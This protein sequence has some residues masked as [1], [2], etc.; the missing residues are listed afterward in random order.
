MDS[1]LA[2]GQ[3]LQGLVSSYAWSMIKM[4]IL[5]RTVLAS[6]SA[7]LWPAYLLK[8]A[9]AVDNPFNLARN[10]SEKAGRILADAIANKVQGERPVTLVG[11]SLGARVIYTCL[12]ALAQRRAFGLVD[13]VVFVGAP[14]PSDAAHW[15]AMRSVVSG[16]MFNVYSQNDYILGFLYR[17]T[18]IQLGVAG[19]QPIEGVDGVENI[20]LSDD[21][22]G[23]LR[24]PDLMPQILAR[25]GF[26]GVK[27]GDGPIEKEKDDDITLREQDGSGAIGTLIELDDL[28]SEAAPPPLPSRPGAGAAAGP[29][30]NPRRP[31]VARSES[32]TLMRE[33][34]P[35][36]S[37]SLESAT[38]V[39]PLARPARPHPELA[40]AAKTEPAVPT[41]ASLSKA[42]GA[43]SQ[44]TAVGAATTAAKGQKEEE[45][46]VSI[47][48]SRS[49]P[50][51]QVESSWAWAEDEGEE[52]NDD[53]EEGFVGIKMMDNDDDM[54]TYDEPLIVED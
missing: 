42:A 27:G 52:E 5:K 48:K 28:P 10:R 47:P 13:T 7:A 50:P 26:P 9:S 31:A 43:A 16:R 38:A 20:D 23:H 15:R 25:C 36:G 8:T 4:E 6:L 35:L 32:E 24:Y 51:P 19:L 22:K 44:E 49:V 41:A 37:L 14:V 12:R 21:V 34:D 2:L 29:R 11:Y 39:K 53:D 1:L 30:P 3:S 17:A 40:A 45:V 54:V 33:L 46:V 18:S